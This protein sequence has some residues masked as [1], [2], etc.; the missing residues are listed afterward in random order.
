MTS[1]TKCFIEMSDVIALHVECNHCHTSLSLSLQE[2][3]KEGVIKKCPSCGMEWTLIKE[4]NYEKVISE[5]VNQLK[6]FMNV[7]YGIAGAPGIPAAPL[8]CS[9]RL[10]I[11]EGLHRH[12]FEGSREV[13]S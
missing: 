10:E 11:K 2:G 12:Q 8:G 4:T 1:Q 13:Q 6:L 7:L 9:V 5:F 3:V